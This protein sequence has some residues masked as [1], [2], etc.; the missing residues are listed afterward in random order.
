MGLFDLLKNKGAPVV[1]ETPPLFFKD[2]RE[3]FEYS[4]NFLDC[5]LHE[6]A[7]LTAIV[8]DAREFIGAAT[9][10]Q[11]QKD[12]NQ[13]AILK[14][15][16][17]DGGFIVIASTMVPKVPQLELGDFVA[18]RASKYSEDV[19]ASMGAKDERSGWIGLILGTLKP[20]RRN[21]GWVGNSRFTP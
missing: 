19:A 18:W 4:C 8:L 13:V 1:A 2:G 11:R 9:S 7:F 14:V 17:K 12:G 3:A 21:G 15:A 5:P 20:E 10:I 16:A 6:G